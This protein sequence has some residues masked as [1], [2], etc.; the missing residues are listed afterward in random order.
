MHELGG[1]CIG[2][3]L[4]FDLSRIAIGHVR[5]RGSN[6]NAFSLE[7]SADERRDRVR[8]QHRSASSAR[9][10]TASHRYRGEPYRARFPQQRVVIELAPRSV[11]STLDRPSVRSTLD[12]R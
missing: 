7:L 6:R 8:V 11:R 2:F 5:G 4:P 9:S 1:L 12:P 10:R 3:N